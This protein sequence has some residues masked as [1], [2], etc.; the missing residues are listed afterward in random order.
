MTNKNKGK[1]I[2]MLSPENYIRKKARSLSIHECWINSDWKD[3]GMASIVVSRRHTNENITFCLYLVDLMCLGIKDTSYKFNV[4]ETEFRNFIERMEERMQMEMIDYILAHNII[5]SAVEF[6]EEYGFNPH[7]D[8]T[9]V[10]EY[11]LEEDTDDIELM[12]I[13]CGK[14]GKPLYIQG[15]YD[16]DAKANK[17][18]KQLEHSAG[19]GNYDFIKEVD[20]DEWEE[21]DDEWDE[22]D[23]LDEDDDE[24]YDDWE[25]VKDN[26]LGNDFLPLFTDE[27]IGKSKDIIAK[28][29]PRIYKLKPKE[30][31]R[32]TEAISVV[33][34]SLC[35]D[36]KVAESLKDFE[37]EFE[38]IKITKEI[39]NEM[40]G[41]E[42]SELPY[43]QKIKE[44]FV[45]GYYQEG[46]KLKKTINELREIA[47]ENAGVANLELLFLQSESHNKLSEKLKY[48]Y[49][50]FPENPMVKISY[51]IEKIID[52]KNNNNFILYGT[53]LT[54]I[55]GNR[56]TINQIEWYN[57]FVL[58]L[59]KIGTENNPSKL[60]AF[61][62]IINNQNFNEDELYD[63]T[64]TSKIVQLECTLNNL[65]KE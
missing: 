26:Q 27:E 18:M 44:L 56:R 12:E 9:S 52:A 30:L 59:F 31:N 65:K 22:E 41:I 19:R 40:L 64:H 49:S 51:L 24:D 25:E 1:V 46:K 53:G 60:L 14:D 38:N 16:S 28:L 43:N 48:Y 45:K 63:L 34:V 7:K 54:Q 50:I 32:F 2:Q 13:E 23:D 11:M 35:D 58:L 20:S 21:E 17:I 5:L 47:G 3:S 42:N 36:D 61:T 4:T 29:T 37:H 8:F 33:F 15:P 55:F 6:A 57:Y 10:T 39:P 62:Q